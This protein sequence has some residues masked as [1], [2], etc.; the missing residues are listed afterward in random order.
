M[1]L[2]V[3]EENYQFDVG[4]KELISYLQGII[5]SCLHMFRILHALIS[6]ISLLV[7]IILPQVRLCQE[8]CIILITY[9]IMLRMMVVIM[10]SY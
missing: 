4:V 2:H 3:S 10:F 8:L 9:L 7:L 1:W 6:L 5:V